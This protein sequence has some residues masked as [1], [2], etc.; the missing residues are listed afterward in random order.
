MKKEMM[1]NS[2]NIT[3]RSSFSIWLFFE[4]GLILFVG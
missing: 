2:S 1:L 3:R 4:E